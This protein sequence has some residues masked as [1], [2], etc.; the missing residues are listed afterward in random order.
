MIDLAASF[1]STTM[2]LDLL[3]RG[4]RHLQVVF[5]G[6]ASVEV[7]RYRYRGNTIATPWTPKPAT[8][9]TSD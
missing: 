8:A 7:K 6:A 1:T 2:P 5:T 9:V 3:G 4:F